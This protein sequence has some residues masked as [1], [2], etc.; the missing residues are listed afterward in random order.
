[1]EK[2]EYSFRPSWCSIRVRFVDKFHSG[3]EW[4]KIVEDRDRREG[5]LHVDTRCKIDHRSERWCPQPIEASSG[6]FGDSTANPG[7]GVTSPA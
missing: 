6:S 1:V 7:K 2:N 5:C 4:A 3:P